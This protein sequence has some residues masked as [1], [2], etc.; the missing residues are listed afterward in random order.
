VKAASQLAHSRHRIGTDGQLVLGYTIPMEPQSVRLHV[1][2]GPHMHHRLNVEA[3]RTGLSV[4]ELIRRAVEEVYST[5]HRPRLHGW[6]A[7]LGFWRRPDA[8]I[9]GRRPGIR[10]TD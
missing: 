1:Q 6:Q 3:S 4:A 9:A 7:S 2:M 5:S 10:L 8:A